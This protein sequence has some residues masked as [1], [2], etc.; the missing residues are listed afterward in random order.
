MTIKWTTLGRS[1]ER[2]TFEKH[3]KLFDLNG[4]NNERKFK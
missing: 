4:R 1:N 3:S 2:I